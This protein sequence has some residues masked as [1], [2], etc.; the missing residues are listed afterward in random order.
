[1]TYQLLSTTHCSGIRLCLLLLYRV[2]AMHSMNGVTTPMAIKWSR[3]YALPDLPRAM[4]TDTHDLVY[5]YANDI[6]ALYVGRTGNSVAYRHDKHATEH[7]G[8]VWSQLAT[9]VRYAR[10][11]REHSKDVET[12]LIHRLH[13]YGNK[14]CYDCPNST[15]PRYCTEH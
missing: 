3:W 15:N 5:M 2:L 9:K 8:K 13:P 6:T 1:M 14:Q 10:I 11:P 12:G 7:W 4:A